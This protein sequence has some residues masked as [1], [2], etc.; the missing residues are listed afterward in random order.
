MV[1]RLLVIFQSFQI[2][3]FYFNRSKLK[4]SFFIQKLQKFELIIYIKIANLKNKTRILSLYYQNYQRKLMFNIENNEVQNNE[5]VSDE[6]FDFLNLEIPQLVR[7]NGTIQAEKTQGYFILDK[8]SDKIFIEDSCPICL[9]ENEQLYPLFCGHIFCENDINKL[10]LDSQLQKNILQ[11]PICR[12][13]QHVESFEQLYKLK[14]TSINHI[15][16]ESNL[17]Y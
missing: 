8:V 3:T 16:K 11:C 7:R 4:V 1:L 17:T 9:C 10:L 2:I 13:Y 15:Q 12:Q 5:L 14:F 6:E